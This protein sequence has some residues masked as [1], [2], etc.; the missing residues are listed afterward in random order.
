[1]FPYPSGAGLHVG[2]PEGYTATDILSRFKRAQGYNCLLYTSRS[3]HPADVKAARIADLF[4][5]QSFLDPSVLGTYPEELVEILAEHD[6]LPEYTAEELELIREH[7]VDFLGVNYYQPLRVMAPRFAMHPDSPLL[8][9]H[10]YEPYVM[11]GRKINPHRGWEI[12]EQG[13]YQMCIRDRTL[14]AKCLA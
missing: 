13:I 12:Y 9:E 3:Q 10:F 5:A 7:T 4:Q 14:S 8:P 11:P 6:L 1:M 2:H